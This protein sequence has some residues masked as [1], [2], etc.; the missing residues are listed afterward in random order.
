MQTFSLLARVF[1]GLIKRKKKIEKN[2]KDRVSVDE[3]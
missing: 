2:C 1:D 3:L